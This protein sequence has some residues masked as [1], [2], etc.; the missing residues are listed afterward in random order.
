LDH[1]DATLVASIMRQLAHD[2]FDQPVMSN[3]T[4]PLY[5]ERLVAHLLGDEW[6]FV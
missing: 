4:R 3:L 6:K 5:V 2:L 1:H